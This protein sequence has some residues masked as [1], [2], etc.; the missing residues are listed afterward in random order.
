M[1]SKGFSRIKET[2]DVGV[3]NE[4]GD[5]AEE[6]VNV[7]DLGEEVAKGDDITWCG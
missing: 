1:R 3:S 6:G 7:Q 5:T 2:C 4:L